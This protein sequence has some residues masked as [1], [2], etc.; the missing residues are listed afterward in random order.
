MLQAT[1]QLIKDI[2]AEHGVPLSQ[3]F[4]QCRRQRVVLARIAV[5]KALR[6][7]GDSSCKIGRLLN[8]DHS[9]IS[10]Y[11]GRGK[12]RPIRPVLVWKKPHIWHL[13]C[14]GCW[15]CLIVPRPPK[16]PK[17]APVAVRYKAPTYLVPYAGYDYDYVWK[18]RPHENHRQKSVAAAHHHG[19]RG[20]PDHDVC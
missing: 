12:K 4:G 16:L 8:K 19:D 3:I 14:G 11:L 17:R 20:Q 9:T 6:A 1:R 13:H 2:A 18:E 10:V 7:R 5:A 15:R